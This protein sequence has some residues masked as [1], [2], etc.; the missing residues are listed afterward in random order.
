MRTAPFS[1][2]SGRLLRKSKRCNEH[3]SIALFQMAFLLSAVGT[4]QGGLSY[5][6][7]Q[8]CSKHNNVIAHPIRLFRR[9]DME[10]S[11][12]FVCLQ[13]NI[14][15]EIMLI[16][17]IL[18]NR[19]HPIQNEIPSSFS[20]SISTN[21]HINILVE[22]VLGPVINASEYELCRLWLGPPH[23]THHRLHRCQRYWLCE[24][25]TGK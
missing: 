11:F 6:I 5:F 10:I 21:V 18:L 20:L 15:D 14:C 12:P 4:H 7:C 17:Q 1:R 25:C 13:P 3:R 16:L 23:F 22:T 9:G 2:K 19:L 24:I 8:N